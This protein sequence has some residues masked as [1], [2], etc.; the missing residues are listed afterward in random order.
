MKKKITILNDT[1]ATLLSG[2][3]I[4]V[5]KN[6]SQYIGFILGTGTN[7]SCII[8]DYIYNVES[9]GFSNFPFSEIDNLV[10]SSSENSGAYRFEKA[11]SGAY[12][13]TLTL[14]FMQKI[15]CDDFFFRKRKFFNIFTAIY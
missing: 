15:S 6:I 10:D 11:I 14:K 9:G 4:G 1:V 3:T 12:L 7:S 2:Y 13:G 5:K 8:N